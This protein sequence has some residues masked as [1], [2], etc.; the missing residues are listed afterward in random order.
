MD[1]LL[2]Y[3]VFQHPREDL[4]KAGKGK[5]KATET[6]ILRS[7]LEGAPGS[8]VRDGFCPLLTVHS[9]TK[10]ALEC[11]K[12]RR[13]LEERF[14]RARTKSGKARRVTYIRKALSLTA[15]HQRTA[16]DDQAYFLERQVLDCE[17][18]E[19]SA[20]TTELR[21]A[22]SELERVTR[23]QRA[24]ALPQRAN[25]YS[26]AP[27][28]YAHHY[29]TYHYPYA[30]TYG[31]P[32]GSTAAPQGYPYSVP[33]SSA[34]SQYVPPAL[35][36]ATSTIKTQ[37]AAAGSTA[38]AASAPI[39]PSPLT[40]AS[41][42]SI[43]VPTS[44]ASGASSGAIPVQLPVS[45]L[46]TLH[47]L[48]I[49]PVPP[50]SLSANSPTPPA[51]LR[52]TSANGAMLNLEINVPLLQ[53]AQ[54]SGLALVLNSIMRSSSTT[55]TGEVPVGAPYIYPYTTAQLSAATTAA[56][57]STNAEPNKTTA[58]PQEQEGKT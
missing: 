11:F 43:P 44:S 41:D 45:S 15:R 48:G 7:E 49:V 25:Y 57:S 22:K 30:Q 47:A 23:L 50:Q 51:V 10:F 28:V 53:A 18:A 54:M 55:G 32:A 14:R 8:P 12:R 35:A 33:L 17:R 2:P 52:G 4:L 58:Q 37:P 27:P 39:T 16:S 20:L 46:P 24:A 13:E 56:T 31:A 5:Q 36:T 29:R 34:I 42:T 1:R 38:G 21:N 9:E 26:P 40:P 3:H 6:D 19:H